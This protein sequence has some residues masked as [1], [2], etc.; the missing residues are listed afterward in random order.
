MNKLKVKDKDFVKI[1]NHNAIIEEVKRIAGEINEEYKDDI[2]VFLSVLNG[3]FMFT[4]D[5][6]KEYK[7]NCELSFIQLAS[8]SG[9]S[10]TGNVEM[11]LDI[12]K[13]INNKRVII[14]EDIVDTGI[15][16]SYLLNY[17]KKRNPK[18]V[19][20]ATF[21]FKPDALKINLNLDYVGME[22]SNDFII[23]YGLDYDG[24]GRNLKDIYKVC[25]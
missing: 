11:L 1:I 12:N 15:T 17:I 13:N 5:L 20:V 16:I 25:N 6:L 22:V 9:T 14:V 3:A 7:G 2:P 18:D 10:T 23:G 21:L 8:Y 4:S 19:A 24:F